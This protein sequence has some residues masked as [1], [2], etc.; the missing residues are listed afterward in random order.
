MYLHAEVLHEGPHNRL[1]RAT[2]DADGLPVVIKQLRGAWPKPRELARFRR[3][4]DMLVTLDGAGAPRPVAF[5][6][7]D[8]VAQIVTERL[9]GV[10]LADLLAAR[11]LTLDESLTVALRLAEA[12][13]QAH[14]RDVH[15]RDIN[16]TNVLV[17]LPSG[18]VWLIDFGLATRV[19]RG[20]ASPRPLASLEGTPAYLAP[21][22]TGR[23]NRAVDARADLYALGA[24][25]YT[26]F[27]G[28][29]PFAC[30]DLLEYVHAHLAREPAPLAS[31]APGVP[32][33]VAELVMT[34]LRKR[35]E[36]RYQSAAGVA[37]DLRRCL[38]A[39]DRGV[40]TL[41]G[42]ALSARPE[43]PQDLLGREREL[44]RL[45]AAFDAVE[46]GGRGVVLVSGEPGIGKTSLVFE[47]QR[48]ATVAGARL[49]QG[50]FDQYTRDVPFAA[51]AQAL[52]GFFTDA[53]SETHAA[54]DAWRARILAAV[55]PNGRL[56][57]DLVPGAAALLGAQPEA[58][59]LGPTEAER[60]LQE[61][62]RR[63]IGAVAQPGHAVVLFLDDLQWADLPSLHLLETLFDD[64]DLGHLLLV[65][66]WRDTEV[67]AAHALGPT[68]EALR[69]SGAR[70][71]ALH[72][73]PLR[74]ADGER[75]LGHALHV[76][77]EAT[78]EL[79]AV[80]HEK[81]RGNPFFLRRLVEELGDA[82]VLRFDRAALAWRWDLAAVRERAVT[83]NVVTYLRRDLERL[84]GDAR[85]CLSAAAWIGTRFELAL[86]GEVTG[87]APAELLAAL[88]G[89]IERRFVVPLDD[90][91]WD[92]A[93]AVGRDFGFAFVHDRIQQ[94]AG[95]LASAHETAR[96]RL[97]LARAMRRRG[98]DEADVFRMAEHFNAAVE[99]VD[100]PAER[101]AVVEVNFEAGRRAMLSAAYA[102]AHR[103]LEAAAALAGPELWDR[104]PAFARSLYLMAARAAWLVGDLALMRARVDEL[105][106]RPGGA[107]ERLDAEWVVIQ[108]QIAR[109][110]LH[111]GITAAL[112]ALE[113]V[114]VSLP[115]DPTVEEVRAGIGA[116]LAVIGARTTADLAALPPCRDPVEEAARRM[117]VGISSASYVATPN[118][119]PLLSVELVIRTAGRGLSRE[120]SFG[121]GVFALSLC[122]GW[123]LALGYEYGRLALRLLDRMPDAASGGRT[124][125]V[126]NHFVR[127]WTEPSREIHRETS[128][129]AR[130]LMDVGDLEYAGWVLELQ[131]V[132]ALLSGVALDAQAAAQ[133][134]ALAFMRQHKLFAA[135]ETTIQ[136]AQLTRGLRGES[137]D[138]SRLV[139]P[140]YDE[141]TALAGYR[142]RA[143][144]AG[145]LVLAVCML[146]ARVIFRDHAGAVEAAAL[147]FEF[148]DGAL[149]IGYQCTMRV[150]AA[151]A[152]LSSLDGLDDVARAARIEA[153]REWRPQV[154][155]AA[156]RSDHNAGHLLALFD[157]ELARAD[158]DV[159]ATIERYDHAIARAAAGGFVHDEALAGERAGLFHL[160]RGSR[161]IARA[162]LQDARFA[163]QRWGATAKVA[164]LDALHGELLAP[165]D[166]SSVAPHTFGRSTELPG[167][168]LDLDTM[169]KASQAI[170]GEVEL[171]GL[172][173]RAMRILLEN[174]G[175]RKGVLLLRS[176]GVLAIEAEGRADSGAVELLGGAAFEDGARVPPTIVRRV[177]RRG[178]AEVHDDVA[179]AP[180]SALDP[181]LQRVRPRS[182]LCAPV[183]HQGRAMGVLYF[184]N[185][186]SAG[187]FTEARVR[188]LEVLAPQVA[189][190]VENARLHAAQDRFVPYQF[191]RSLNR[192]DIVEVEIGDHAL[193]EVSV[194]FSDIRGFTSLIERLPA[195]EALTFINSY[196]AT[197]EPAIQGHGGFIDTYLGDGIMALFDAPRANADDAVAGAVAMHHALDAF[198]LA[199][200]GRGLRPVRTGIGINTGTVM[201]ATIGGGRSLKCGVVGD[202]VNLAA[203]VEGLTRRYEV[204]VLISDATLAAM[205]APQRVATRRV[206]RVRVKGREQPLTLYEVI[207]AESEGAREARR[208]TLAVHEAAVDAFFARDFAGAQAGF[209]DCLAAAPDDP[210]PLY[211]LN[212]LRA[213]IA[214]GVPA[215]WD[216]VETM[217][218]K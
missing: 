128:D 196:F 126:V 50:K 152:E 85:R 74:P 58:E 54:V 200:D 109:G 190:S 62:F 145:A 37:L 155:T 91:Y 213:L 26:L 45:A 18:S 40:V 189:I 212:R 94:A 30:A 70:V 160:A 210:L 207:D 46:R 96:T 107:V 71:E 162:Y 47:L 39:D 53:L 175:A 116:A 97:A 103:L 8:G 3:E 68:V 148:Q 16:P 159:G 170:S 205:R 123:H 7:H 83:D 2:R 164:Q 204:R 66:A 149:A 106:A 195:A 61:T 167:A 98:A 1:T 171:A 202:A 31:V 150:L 17:D 65:G 89:A 76:A 177:W 49:L 184:E 114:G 51:V 138:P 121:F 102:P 24:T 115:R 48:P 6:L 198:N 64:R 44:A 41:V 216:G 154:Q 139:G 28:R 72:L 161:H 168:T 112:R 111:E 15:H 191:L 29:P 172:L 187:A 104:N 10:S 69:A 84:S 95:E 36:E 33:P 82:H 173:T 174:V 185:D 165:A 143:Y 182:V 218:E 105:R 144:R 108:S 113:E 55:G 63:V 92:A 197:A 153:V 9:P 38:E 141:A 14:A 35:P 88:H 86:L 192:S 42:R 80:L 133:E 131:S 56:L 20:V 163:W 135:H 176:R 19:T 136:F 142:A 4:Y 169:L 21:E 137:A 181:Y 25:L 203:R 208:R 77:P 214:E 90:G 211:F 125:H 27:A 209:A 206:G 13:E 130:S 127:A 120:S 57:T 79:A 34:L 178:A 188:V 140:E 180:D 99:L 59:E 179:D 75:I 134:R 157:A 22:Q 87:I 11:T 146:Y 147:A 23:M 81:T 100:D 186:L 93:A 78:R 118:L 60:R 193:K 199:R 67:D 194:F 183:Q 156:E 5:E 166:R 132:Y 124:R 217:T 129:L 158:G 119:L 73:G 110:E 122:A 43:F 32:P 12:V 215:E 52:D 151:V 201:L 117:M 101:A